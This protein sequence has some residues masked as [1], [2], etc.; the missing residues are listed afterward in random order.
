MSNYIRASLGKVAFYQD[1]FQTA[2][3][4]LWL[5]YNGLEDRELKAATLF[6][7]AKSQQRSGQFDQADQS[8]NN[9]VARYGDT[10]WAKRASELRGQRAFYIQLALYEKDA[11]ADAAANLVTQRGLKPVRLVDGQGRHI[12]RAGPYASYAQAKQLREKVADAFKDA[13]IIP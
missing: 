1:D 5:A 2:I 9:V 7:L 4:Q 12:L 10:G 8:F 11:S 6:H 3:Q 13:L